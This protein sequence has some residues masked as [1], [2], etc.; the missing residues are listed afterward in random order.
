MKKTFLKKSELQLKLQL[1]LQQHHNTP[2]KM[3]VSKRTID[4]LLHEIIL[5]Y[6][7]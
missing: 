5:L 6:C 4:K 7:H 3:I 1:K 2:K